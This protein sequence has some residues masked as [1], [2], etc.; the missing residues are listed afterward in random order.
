MFGNPYFYS[1]A[2]NPKKQICLASSA[3]RLLP[4]QNDV[5]LAKAYSSIYGC[6]SGFQ[7]HNIRLN[8]LVSRENLF[9]GM[10]T[11]KPGTS[12]F[13]QSLPL[14]ILFRMSFDFF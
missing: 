9:T 12:V 7:Q 5:V 8:I 13:L 2:G 14:V 11:W 3:A 6:Y 10:E 1:L 4:T